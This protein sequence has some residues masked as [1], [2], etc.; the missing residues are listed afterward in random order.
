MELNSKTQQLIAKHGIKVNIREDL[1]EKANQV[2]QANINHPKIVES[3]RIVA[4]LD[5]K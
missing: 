3:R 2:K 1:T 4:K 5:I